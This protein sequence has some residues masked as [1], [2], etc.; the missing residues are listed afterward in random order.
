MNGLSDL[1]KS[2]WFTLKDII[3]YIKI[4]LDILLDSYKFIDIDTFQTPPLILN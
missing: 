2:K 4:M 1:W 3:D